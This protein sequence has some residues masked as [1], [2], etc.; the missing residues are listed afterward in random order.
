MASP[1]QHFREEVEWGNLSLRIKGPS[2]EEV[3]ASSYLRLQDG[4][5]VTASSQPASQL[6][7]GKSQVANILLL[8]GS[9]QSIPPCGGEQAMWTR[10]STGLS[11]FRD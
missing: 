3:Q 2:A 9:E 8:L 11:G 1:F 5:G 6:S 10:E 7:R 4:Q